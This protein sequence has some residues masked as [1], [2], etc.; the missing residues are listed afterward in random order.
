M[1]RFVH[2]PMTDIFFIFE[3]LIPNQ[4]KKMVNPTL[5]KLFIGKENCKEVLSNTNNK[6]EGLL[7]Y[8]GGGGIIKHSSHYSL[9]AEE[10]RL[11]GST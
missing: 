1:I 10:L 5:M 4:S 6:Y 11:R 7:T 3:F 8:L 2:S 9:P